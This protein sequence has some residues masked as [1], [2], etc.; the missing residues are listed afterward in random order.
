MDAWRYD[1]PVFAATDPIVCLSLALRPSLWGVVF[2]ELQRLGQWYSWRYNGAPHA[3]I[4][5]VIKEIQDATDSAIFSG[6]TMIG[7][8]KYL[9]RAPRDYELI[10]DGTVYDRVD[11]PDLYASLQ[12]AYIIDADTFRVP[13]L[14][15]RF[16]MGAIIAGGEGGVDSVTLTTTELP[17]HTHSYQMT[18]PAASTVLGELPGIE[19]G[20]YSPTATGSA[21]SGQPFS[22][23]NPYHKLLPVILARRPES[24][25]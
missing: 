8:I 9:A 21:G 15:E 5:E 19:L 16:P 20:D 17:A 6:C 10:C 11:Y 25:E 22:V 13:D 23:V 4:G 3:T 12:A 14:I 18:V 1:T 24:G 7:D 2:N